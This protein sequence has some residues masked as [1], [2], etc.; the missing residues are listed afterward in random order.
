MNQQ[1]A[2]IIVENIKK[3]FSKKFG[4]TTNINLQ[5]A[6]TIAKYCKRQSD[7]YQLTN[8]RVHY[9]YW[10]FLATTYQ[11]AVDATIEADKMD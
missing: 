7:K 10:T 5:K 2:D 3:E 9:A 6:I 8:H 11:K 1:E 4:D